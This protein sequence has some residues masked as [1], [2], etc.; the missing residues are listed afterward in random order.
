MTESKLREMG[1]FTLQFQ[2]MVNYHEGVK[3]G[4]RN[5]WPH[6]QSRQEEREK[7]RER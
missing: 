5:S 3:A 4:A 6:P 7:E 1:Y 2:I